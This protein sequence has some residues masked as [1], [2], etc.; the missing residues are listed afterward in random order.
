MKL[1]V[2]GGAGFIGSNFVRY[3][4]DKYPKNKVICL[5]NLTYCGNLNNLKDIKDNPNYL[6]VKGDICHK[7]IVDDLMKKVDVCINFAAASHVDRS[8]EEPEE[9]VRTNIQ[10]VQTLLEAA[11]KYKI[12]RVI[13]T[14]TDEVYGQVLKGSSKEA[15]ILKPR[16]PYSAS[17]ASADLLSGAYFE[18][19]KTPIIITRSCNNFGPYQYPEKFIPLFTTNLI[20]NKKV[21]VYGNGRQVREWIY[22]LDNCAAID[23]VLHKGKIGQIYNIG[24]GWHKQNIKITQLILDELGKGKEMIEY[25]KDR[26]A[27]DRRYS[28]NSKKIRELGWQPQYKFGEAMK[29]TINWY[30][31]NKWWWKPLKK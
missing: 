29:E 6:F 2:T 8:I 16:N 9:F 23:L 1:L 26:P 7:K 21:P 17:K 12:K 13:Q 3:I 19:Y 20:E 27:H 4:L 5:D 30:V 28:L 15:D 22:V 10:G 31:K 14:S 24:T 25:V 11:R 18:T